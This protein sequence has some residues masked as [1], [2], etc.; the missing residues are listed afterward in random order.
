MC[1]VI[2]HDRVSIFNKSNLQLAYFIV[3]MVRSNN[4]SI[5]HHFQEIIII[6]IISSA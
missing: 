6:I 1:S 4:V 2:M 5:M 3:L